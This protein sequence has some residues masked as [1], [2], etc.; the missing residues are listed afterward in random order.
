MSTKLHFNDQMEVKKEIA[1]ARRDF[2]APRDLV[3][4]T[5]TDIEKLK[6]AGLISFP[7]PSLL[8]M[9]QLTRQ[10]YGRSGGAKKG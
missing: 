1:A 10:S 3:P 4:L 9:A 7:E 5:P 6:Q 8:T 2:Y